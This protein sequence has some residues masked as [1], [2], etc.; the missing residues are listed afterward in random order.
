MHAS[1]I[2]NSIPIVR[3]HLSKP[4]NVKQLLKGVPVSTQPYAQSLLIDLPLAT[5]ELGHNALRLNLFF[6]LDEN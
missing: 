6:Q 1:I 3:K 5:L 2:P 4:D